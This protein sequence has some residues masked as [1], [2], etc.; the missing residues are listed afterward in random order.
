MIKLIFIIS[1]LQ[2]H[3]GTERV[4]TLLANNLSGYYDVTILSRNING[5]GNSYILNSH[6][7]DIKFNCNN[8]AFSFR[9]KDYVN[10]ESPDIVIIHTM[11]K[12]TPTLLFSG[13]KANKI[14]SIEHTSFLFST[15]LFRSLRRFLYKKLSKVVTLT[16]RDKENYKDFVKEVE[17]I[18]N[19]SPFSIT[20]TPYQ[21]HST[22]VVTIG[23]LEHHKG[24]DLLLNAWKPISLSYPNWTLEIYGL[25]SE[26]T[27]LKEFCK[28]N[29]IETVFFKGITNNPLKVYDSAAMYVMSSRYE[30]LPLVLIEAQSRGLPIV[31]FDCP[32]GPAEVVNNKVDGLL[33]EPNNISALTDSI[34]TLITNRFLREQY[35]FNSTENAR[36]F[37]EKNIISKWVALIESNQ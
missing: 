18:P 14:W 37:T 28:D 15:F 1:S 17:V 10:K 19:A 24:Y 20:T 8:I 32:Y 23:N 11:S 26:E 21:A 2:N 3:G 4:A 30:G 12:L 7:K 5:K 27:N 9:V 33:I 29:N 6:V 16:E 13:L 34:L 31:S 36:R 22:K 25:G 35:S